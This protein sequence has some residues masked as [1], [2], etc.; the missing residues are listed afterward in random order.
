MSGRVETT[1]G[2]P[3]Q[4]F[5]TPHLVALLCSTRNNQQYFVEILQKGPSE[6]LLAMGMFV[7]RLRAVHVG[8]HLS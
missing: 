7:T 3:G 4:I 6:L 1:C 8:S 5:S 2:E